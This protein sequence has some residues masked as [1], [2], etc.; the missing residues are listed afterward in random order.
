MVGW[1]WTQL[2]GSADLSSLGQVEI[3]V[4][5][6]EASPGVAGRER[7]Q[8]PM[9]Q[10]LLISKRAWMEGF[11]LTPSAASLILREWERRASGNC[12]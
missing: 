9:G 6:L 1:A 5:F 12:P 2:D 10:G 11:C 3:L 4:G 7:G 8:R